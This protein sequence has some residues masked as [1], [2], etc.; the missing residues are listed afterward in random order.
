M[1]IDETT[2]HPCRLYRQ[3]QYM[4][5]LRVPFRRRA[6]PGIESRR[7]IRLLKNAGKVLVVTFS[8]RQMIM[9]AKKAVDSRYKPSRIAG[10][11]MRKPAGERTDGERNTDATSRERAL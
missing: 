4:V 9:S 8:A 6:T 2:A 7:F 11:N 5:G 10:A 1:S 3:P